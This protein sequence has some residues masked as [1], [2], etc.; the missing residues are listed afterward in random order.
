VT[1]F[2]SQGRWQRGWYD[3]A[4]TAGEFVRPNASF[5]EMLARGAIRAEPGRYHL[6]VSLACPWA[7][8]TLIMRTL[9]RLEEALPVSIVE[10]VMDEQGWRFSG[11][12][13]DRANA[14]PHLHWL[15]TA[16]RADYSGRVSVPV[17]WDTK[18]RGIVN[19]ESADILRMLDD[20]AEYYPEALRGRIDAMNAFVYENVND[21]VYRCGFA[22]G[23]Q[24]Y[25]RAYDKL[26]DALDRIEENLSH[27][28]F[29][30]GDTIT[31]ADWRLFTTLVRFDAV[32]HG[33]F[34]CNRNRL[35]DFPSLHAYMLDL[36][37]QP[38]IA[39]TV[40]LDHIKQHYYVSHPHLN[41]SR[42][43][44]RG[45]ALDFTGRKQ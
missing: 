14:F 35:G 11:E 4:A 21:G 45:P 10:P 1:G 28:R 24:P 42:I 16:T 44:P 3:T 17:L 9:K 26:F 25:E 6:Y 34:K 30:V 43:V 7:H 33:H 39:A 2:L 40:D 15:Y 18:K 36:Y 27:S 13:P 29:L 41:P 8:R 38:G 5:R 19:N 32:Y 12:L 31:E 37:F 22:S 23:Q 20:D